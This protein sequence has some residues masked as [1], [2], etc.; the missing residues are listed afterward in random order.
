ML[1]ALAIG[2]LIAAVVYVLSG[3]HLLFLPI[4]FLPVLFSF[5]GSR[6]TRRTARGSRW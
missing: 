3:G 6:R 5:G 1:R 2:L 4:L